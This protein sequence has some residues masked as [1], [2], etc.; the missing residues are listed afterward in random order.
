[1]GRRT[2]CLASGELLGTPTVDFGEMQEAHVQHWKILDLH[3]EE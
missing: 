1:M 2:D 3:R